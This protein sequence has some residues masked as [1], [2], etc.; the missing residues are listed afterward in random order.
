M[1]QDPE[2]R[3]EREEAADLLHELLGG[4]PMRV[5]EIRKATNAAGINW[6]TVQRARATIGA[7]VTCEGF[8]GYCLW[9]IGDTDSHTCHTKRD[10][11]YGKPSV[12]CPDSD[13]D[14]APTWKKGN[15]AFHIL[16][17]NTAFFSCVSRYNH[18]AQTTLE[19]HLL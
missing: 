8:G 17:F 14:L 5:A 2:E 15:F 13:P 11:K 4:G 18:N 3:T 6:R 10:G 16:H 1:V 9:S 19:C 12:P 7:V